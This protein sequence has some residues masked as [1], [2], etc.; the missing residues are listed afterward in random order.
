MHVARAGGVVTKNVEQQQAEDPTLAELL[1]LV[2][3]EGAAPVRAPVD[4]G[5]QQDA[6]RK[7]NA[8]DGSIW[9]RLFGMD[10]E[11]MMSVLENAHQR[12][13]AAP[14]RRSSSPSSHPTQPGGAGDTAPRRGLQRAPDADGPKPTK[15]AKDVEVKATK[16]MS[17]SEKF[18]YYKQLI[19]QS[20]GQ[21]HGAPDA[22]NIVGLRNE[23]NANSNGGQGAVDDK[24]VML[25]QDKSGKKHVREYTGT[26]EGSD[27]SR[28]TYSSDVNGDGRNDLGRLGP[29][30]YEYKL[31]YSSTLG[32]VLRTTTAVQVQRDLNQDGKYTGGEKKQDHSQAF[33]F[34][35]G[36]SAGCQTMDAAN[37]SRFWSDINSS[38]RPSKIGYTLLNV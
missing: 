2:P 31:D 3:D 12:A 5:A 18:D 21:F 8:M 4:A 6:R 34:H 35:Q 9:S 17:E 25:W 1:G 22:R 36:T 24:F 29:G 28:R 15:P 33:L 13:S 7:A 27:A 14:P 32:N 30:H 38:G 37:W 26:T 19:Q 10:L 16:G 23:T 11:A 20:G